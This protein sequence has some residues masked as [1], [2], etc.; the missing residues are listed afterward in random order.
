MN[1]LYDLTMLLNTLEELTDE[2]LWRVLG[3]VAEQITKLINDDLNNV[4]AVHFWHIIFCLIEEE[5]NKN[6]SEED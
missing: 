1:K 2:E 3:G 5:I 4:A 6:M